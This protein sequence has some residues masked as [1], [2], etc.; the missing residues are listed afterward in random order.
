M[1]PPTNNWRTEHC[2]YAEIVTDITARN[3]VKICR[4]DRFVKAISEWGNLEH[5]RLFFLY[6]LLIF[7]S[8][9]VIPL[10]LICVL[11]NILPDKK[12]EYLTE[13]N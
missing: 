8:L 2:F 1:S 3:W 13:S 9:R 4:F 7:F 5:Y 6:N 11:G 12:K 10:W